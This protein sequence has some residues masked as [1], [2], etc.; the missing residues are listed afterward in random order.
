MPVAEVVA[1][2]PARGG[3]RGIPRKNV[4]PLAGRPMLAWTIE[5][6]LASKRVSRVI[7]STDDDEIRCV[8]LRYGAEVVIRPAELAT[9]SSKSEDALL[10]ALDQ[11]G[12]VDDYNPDVLVF[13]QCTSPL[14]LPQDIDDAVD[15]L[16]Q[17]GMDTIFSVTDTH[18][19]LWRTAQNGTAIGVNHDPTCRVRRQDRQ[20]EFQENGA[21]YVMRVAGFRKYQHRFFGRIGMLRMPYERSLEIDDMAQFTLVDTLL[22]KR[23][24]ATSFAA[25]EGIHNERK[26][27]DK[28]DAEVQRSTTERPDLNHIDLVVL[29]FD[30]VMT[31]NRVMVTDDGHEAVWCSRADGLGAALLRSAGYHVLCLTS[32]QNAVVAVRCR[33]L[34]IPHL[35]CSSDKWQPLSEYLRNNRIPAENVIY[36]GNDV[37]DLTCIQHVGFPIA[38]ADAHAD[39]QQHAKLILRARGGEGVVRELASFLP[40]KKGCNCE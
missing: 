37:N 27:S 3:S 12:Q 31:D 29:D 14:T 35:A 10:H 5:A 21:V 17:S 39:I 22:A 38:V 34:A 13:L 1:I 6:A 16:M 2:I 23:N 25:G 33:K 19:F 36:V 15:L 11:L 32:E 4:L 40:P 7:V 24:L 26:I 28:N 9:G 18:V 8:A 30:G 20:P